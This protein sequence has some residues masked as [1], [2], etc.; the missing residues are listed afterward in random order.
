MSDFLFFVVE[1]IVLINVFNKQI[2]NY[3]VVQANKVM[4]GIY[5]IIIDEKTCH[6]LKKNPYVYINS[7]KHKIEI[8]EIVPNYYQNY[9]QLL[10]RCSKLNSNTINLS[11]YNYKSDFIENFFKCW[12]ED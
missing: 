4:D 3:Q 12:E 2:P 5:T 11:I 8:I 10:I 6:L 1:L 9:N 7:K